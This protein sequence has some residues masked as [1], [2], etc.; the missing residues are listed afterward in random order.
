MLPADLLEQKTRYTYLAVQTMR[1]CNQSVDELSV[2]IDSPQS[3]QKPL[4]D[5]WA[6]N[7]GDAVDQFSIVCSDLEKIVDPAPKG[8]LIFAGYSNKAS[9]VIPQIVEKFRLFISTH[10]QVNFD[11][12]V[13]HLSKFRENIDAANKELISLIQPAPGD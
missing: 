1:D 10:N 2:L 4:D 7:L 12:A 5:E 11:E 13:K 3:R 9:K 8:F 6:N